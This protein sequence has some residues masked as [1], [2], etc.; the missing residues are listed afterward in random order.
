MGKKTYTNALIHEQSPYL[1]QHA[2]NPVDWVPWSTEILSKA[3]KENKLLLISI[4]YASCHW[5]HVMEHECFED[6]TVAEVMNQGFFNI[7]IDRE[8][9]PDLDQIYMNALQL[10]TGQGG[11]PLNIVALPDGRPIWGATY[12]PKNRWVETLNQLLTLQKNEKNKLETYARQLHQGMK[13]DGLNPHPNDETPFLEALEESTVFLTQ[14]LDQQWGGIKGAPKFMMPCF[15]Q[16]EFELGARYHRTLFKNHVHLSLVKM[17]LGGIFDVLGG[18]FSRYSVDEKW[19]V[20]HFEKMGYD[21]G[22]LMELYSKAYLDQQNP[23]YEEV[24]K[25]TFTFLTTELSDA[26]G[27]FYSSLDADSISPE[28]TLEEGAYYRWTKEE[29]EPLLRDEK[30]HFINYF[31]VNTLGKWEENYYIFFRT[32]TEENYAK[33]NKLDHQKFKSLLKTWHKSLVE[34]REKRARP[35][36]DDKI[37][38][39]W[40]ALIGSG[41]LYAYR[42]FQ[43]PPFLEQAKKNWQFFEQ[44]LLK[45][46]GGLWRIHKRGRST[47]SG[48]LEDYSCTIKFLID[49][50]E[51]TFEERYLSLAELLT[52]YCFK[53]FSEESEPLFFFTE[54]TNLILRTKEIQDNVIPSSNAIMAENLMRLG[55]HLNQTSYKE[56]S[57]KMLNALKDAVLDFPRS[58]SYWGRLFLLNER[59]K[60][61]LVVT[62][63]QAFETIGKLQKQSN[64]PTL[65]A[66]AEKPSELPLFHQRFEVDKTQIFICVN[67]SCQLPTTDIDEALKQLRSLL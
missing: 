37:I 19:H 40:N 58:Y 35:R 1:L 10:L 53:H 20:P 47:V 44:H 50:Y 62:G 3:K 4:G 41:M 13:K 51:T 55:Q 64:V 2:H 21:N 42:S 46:E 59:P 26:S 36:L 16:W 7:K 27:A 25:R 63:P 14:K 11:W 48:F 60:I 22:Q 18:G 24:V 57:L 56:R 66:A 6:P 31:N 38:C 34:E 29:L 17:A 43:S 32:H 54:A 8:E 15:L 39:A 45:K 5:C 12:L 52:S 65:W 23:L 9:R 30:E 61:E 28:G 67:Q 49:F 33:E